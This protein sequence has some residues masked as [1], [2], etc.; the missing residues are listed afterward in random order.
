MTRS[1]FISREQVQIANLLGAMKELNDLRKRYDALGLSGTFVEADIPGGQFSPE[2]FMTAVS[3]IGGIESYLMS[4]G[5][6]SLF[7]VV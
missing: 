3:V 2:E 1:E 5:Y 4:G 7:K 6:T